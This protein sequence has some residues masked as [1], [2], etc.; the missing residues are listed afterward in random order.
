[1]LLVLKYDD[2]A[3]LSRQ[4]FGNRDFNGGLVLKSKLHVDQY[5]C[6]RVSRIIFIAILPEE[7]C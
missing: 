6:A 5:R 1:M 7:I 4:K 2:W 3:R